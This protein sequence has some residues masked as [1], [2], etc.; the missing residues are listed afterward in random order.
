MKGA[1]PNIGHGTEKMQVAGRLV[2]SRTG[3]FPVPG[4]RF[5][6][7]GEAHVNDAFTLIS[8]HGRKV[9]SSTSSIARRGSSRSVRAPAAQ[10]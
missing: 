1:S 5:P 4:L 7:D 9:A 10:A 6:S 8:E 3:A 2:A